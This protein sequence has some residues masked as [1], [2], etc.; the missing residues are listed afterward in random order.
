MSPLNYIIHHVFMPPKLP[1]KDDYTAEYEEALCQTIHESAMRYASS[2]LLEPEDGPVWDFV[3]KMLSAI[4]QSQASDGMSIDAIE[5]D[6]MKMQE[7]SIVAYLIRAQNAGVIF[8]KSKAQVVVASFEVS[9]PAK[10]VICAQGKL[11]C[12]YPGPAIAVPV[13]H[14]ENPLFVHELASFLVQ[15]NSDGLDSMAMTKKAGVAVVEERETPSPRY[16]TT[17]LTGI[18]RGIGSPADVFRIR[19]RISDEVLWKDARLP[20]RRSMVWLVIRVAM[21]LH[22][23]DTSHY[24]RFMVFSMSQILLDGV[25]AGLDSDTL[26]S[27]LVKIGTRASKLGPSIP[28]VLLNKVT[29]AVETANDLLQSRWNKAIEEDAQCYPWDPEILL[30]LEEKDCL[31]S[32]PNSRQYIHDV[33]NRNKPTMSLSTFTPDAPPRLLQNIQDFRNCFSPYIHDDLFEFMDKPSDM[34]KALADDQIIA[35]ADLEES[36]QNNLHNWINERLME[37]TTAIIL[38][39]ILKKYLA[40]AKDSYHFQEDNSIMILTLF[41]VWIALDT[42]AVS[43]HPLL[44][45]YSPEIPLALFEPLLLRRRSDIDRLIKIHQYISSRHDRAS[46]G[47]VFTDVNKPN[48]FAVRFFDSSPELQS[49]KSKIEED[50]HL[51]REKR[52][53]EY[54]NKRQEYRDKKAEAEALKCSSSGDGTRKHAKSERRDCPKCILKKAM[55]KLEIQIHEWPLPRDAN[56]AKAVVFELNCPQT[57]AIWRDA[58]SILL[59]DLC[60]LDRGQP[61]DP[62]VTL[63]KYTVLSK[64]NITRGVESRISI[65]STTKSFLNSHYNKI[66]LSKAQSE[67]NVLVD[68]A[69]SYKLYDSVA[70]IWVANSFQSLTISQWCRPQISASSPYAALQFAVESTNYSHNAVIAQKDLCHDSLGVH[71]FVAF[72]SVRNGQHLQWLNIAKEIRARILSFH[73][74]DTYLLL[75][76]SAWQIGSISSSGDLEW[77][78]DLRSSHFCHTLLSEL[79]NLLQDVKSSW[80]EAASVRAIIALCARVLAATDDKDVQLQGH[81][82]MRLARSVTYKWMKSL[83]EELQCRGVIAVGGTSQSLDVPQRLNKICE[84]ALTCHSTYDVDRKHMDYLLTSPEDVAIFVECSIQNFNN[85]PS[86]WNELPEYMQLIDVVWIRPLLQYGQHA[87]RGRMNHGLV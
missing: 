81:C 61:A 19:K 44:S 29:Q 52:R 11:S 6:L 51:T 66:K 27:M 31:L 55:Q 4:T 49:L 42:I 37:P 2:G 72:G 21:Q 53:K 82:L 62:A 47:T 54:L 35:L 57:F 28:D 63:D 17:L 9:P 75:V 86:S 43:T 1:Q 45:S 77:H 39:N 40:A 24:K 22:L 8:H 3:V 87:F 76:Q 74:E 33:M 68:N 16:I 67:D 25:K 64:L 56:A 10:S 71:E 12:S 78:V 48:S 20:W 41:E 79:E 65:A 58:T 80:M 46:R 85:T 7:G 59:G 23:S 32:L 14:F 69:L 50:A 70:K 73:T 36:I 30:A 13:H 60:K 5:E 15:M 34:Q 84:I 18:M 83:S 38:F 26:H